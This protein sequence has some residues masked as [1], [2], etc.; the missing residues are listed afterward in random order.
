MVDYQSKPQ[1][2]EHLSKSLTVT[3]YD[4]KWIPSSARFV[5]LGS[6]PKTTGCLQVYELQGSDL[7]LLKEVEKPS[8]FKCGSFGASSLADRQLATGNFSGKLQL[9]DLEDTKT[10]LFDVQAHASIVNAIDGCGGQTR[11]YGPP[12][13][14]SCGRDGCVRVWDVRQKDAPVA[15]FEPSEKDDARDCWCV[16]FGN[17]Y[18]DEERRILAGYD[19]GDVKMFDLRTNKV[20]WEDNLK[21]GVCGVQFDRKDIQMNKFIATCLESQFHVFEARTHHPKKGFTSVMES[22]TKGTTI[23]SCRH[24]PQNRDLFMVCGGDGTLSLYKYRYPDQRKIKDS[25]GVETGVAGTVDLLSYKNLSTQPIASLDW[26][27]DKA[28]LFVCSSFDQCIRVGICTKL[29]K[30]G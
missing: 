18:N 4:C 15:A 17:S 20:L 27:P 5:A 6:Y 24:L 3:I 7:K 30:V 23:W 29:N 16:A 21:N 22:M 10:P 2:L 11:G 8:S 25:N 19:N 14:A 13:I 12:E 28:G 26:S 9:W 1:I